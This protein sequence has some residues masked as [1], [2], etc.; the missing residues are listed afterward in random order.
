MDTKTTVEQFQ[1]LLYRPVPRVAFDYWSENL[2]YN[3]Q[4]RSNEKAGIHFL[5]QTKNRVWEMG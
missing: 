3:R 5:T 4:S 1:E 2:L